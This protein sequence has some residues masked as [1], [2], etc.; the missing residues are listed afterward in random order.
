MGGLGAAVYA[1]FILS[2]VDKITRVRL[3]AGRRNGRELRDDRAIFAEAAVGQIINKAS[4]KSRRTSRQL[5][6]HDVIAGMSKGK[7]DPLAEA[8]AESKAIE[9]CPQSGKTSPTPS[10]TDTSGP[11]GIWARLRW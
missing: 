4:G 5:G 10:P 1:T 6:P 8:T 9:S 7:S 11:H 3:V 2:L